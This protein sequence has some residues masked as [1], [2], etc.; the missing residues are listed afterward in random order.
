MTVTP[1]YAGVLA[2]LFLSFSLQVIGRRRIA[3][4]GL[5]DGGDRLLLR[6]QR[7]HGNFAEYVPLV[8]VLMALAELQGLAAWALHIFGA[9]LLIGRVVHGFGVG[10][11][12]E[13]RLTRVIGMSLTF[14]VLGFAAFAVIAMS[15]RAMLTGTG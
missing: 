9:T 1:R 3:R 12:P 15:V 4:V 10:R 14:A 2:L 5:G 11:E 8:L 13:P 6:R 7:V